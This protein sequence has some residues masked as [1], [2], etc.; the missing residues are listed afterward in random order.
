MPRSCINAAPRQTQGF[1]H[2]KSVFGLQCFYAPQRVSV[3]RVIWRGPGVMPV[4]LIQYG[5]AVCERASPL[6]FR[7]RV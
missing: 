7:R 6:T 2:Y 3:R 5:R 1:V 4:F